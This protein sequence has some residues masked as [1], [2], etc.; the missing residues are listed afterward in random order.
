MLR[1]TLAVAILLASS[2][3]LSFA[4]NLNGRWTGSMQTDNGDFQLTFNFKVDGSKLTGAVES[5][6]GD[7]PIEDGKVDGNTFTFKTH[8]NDAEVNHQGTLNGD[9]IDLKIQ[10][11]WG[12]SEMTLKREEEKKS[13]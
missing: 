10:G 1:R 4:G 2:A 12:D 7:I 3:V 8:F 5:P 13:Q 9:T 11:P 6:N